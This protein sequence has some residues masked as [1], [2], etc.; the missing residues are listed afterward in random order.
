M[1]VSA[2]S[3][4]GY[5]M[6]MQDKECRIERKTINECERGNWFSVTCYHIYKEMQMGAYDD[7]GLDHLALSSP[8]ATDPY[9]NGSAHEK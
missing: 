3:I 7:C 6:G 2:V 9:L 5:T 1:G 8:W 4:I